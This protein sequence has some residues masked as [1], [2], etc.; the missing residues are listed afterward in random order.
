M[1]GNWFFI[2]GE[3]M[4]VTRFS[5]AQRQNGKTLR[6][7]LLAWYELNGTGNAVDSHTSGVSLVQ[8]GTVPSVTGKVGNARSFNDPSSELNSNNALFNFNKVYMCFWLRFN[9]FVG[10]PFFMAK[11]NFTGDARGYGFNSTQTNKRLSWAVSGNGIATTSIQNPLLLDENQFYMVEAYHNP[12]TDLIGIAINRGAFS[13]AS[14]STGIFNPG[15]PFSLGKVS[16]NAFGTDLKGVIDNLVIYSDI[17]NEAKRDLL[18]N[19]GKGIR[20]PIV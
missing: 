1:V 15:Q 18:W 3:I 13:T 4:L 5:T 17:P 7:N 16:G 2:L 9:S 8:T 12:D 11:W 20:Y 19:Q 14:H 10:N 6:E